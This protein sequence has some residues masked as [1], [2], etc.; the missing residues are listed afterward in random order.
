MTHDSAQQ[1]IQSIPDHDRL[2]I[3]GE[4]L[5]AWLVADLNTS[6]EEAAPP[7]TGSRA[8]A[9]L[10]TAEVADEAVLRDFFAL[11]E[12]PAAQ[13]VAL[14]D[15][16]GDAELAGEEPVQ[17]FATVGAASSMASAQP[18][19][20]LVLAI[21]AFAWQRQYPLYQ[22]DPDSPPERYSP[23]GQILTRAAQ[24]M[25]RQVQRSATERDKLARLLTPRPGQAASL[26][27]M[28]AGG[29]VA[30]LPPHYRSPIPVRYPEVARETLQVDPD[31]ET[32]APAQRGEPLT[33]AE[34]DLPPEPRAE[35]MPPITITR[36]QVQP[37]SPPSPVP[38]TGVLMPAS[39]TSSRPGLT[40]AL[41]QMFGNEELKTTRLHVVV[42]EYPDGPGLHGLQVK[43]SCKG[44]RSYVAG[45]TDREGSFVAE[46]PVRL[47]EGL[48]YD[49]EVTWPR[50][51]SGETER[52]AIT[53]NADRTRFTLPFYHRSQPGTDDR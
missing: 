52:K 24:F 37:P 44:I 48:T 11:L 39:A 12:Q 41:R 17:A 7:F 25:R 33:I 22:L 46:L 10:R 14:Y 5:G 40:V 15:L 3:F 4:Q 16:L 51:F 27:N 50:D 47:V 36:E 20:W 13:R 35:R 38:P 9:L 49:V 28:E 21:A 18:L 31:E 26:E 34:D 29:P 2:L 53:L 32:P 43:V 1:L 8:K 42:Q 45:T 30:P 23:A 19:D 6:A